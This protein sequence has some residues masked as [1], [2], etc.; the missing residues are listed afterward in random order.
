MFVLLFNYEFS[1]FITI[2]VKKC[3][4][5]PIRFD[6]DGVYFSDGF[7]HIDSDDFRFSISEKKL[8]GNKVKK[9]D[10]LTLYLTDNHVIVGVDINGV[11]CY[12]DE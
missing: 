8:N 10:S 1:K 4:C 7:F 12:L 6:V 5:T 2:M 9:G 11:R 3:K